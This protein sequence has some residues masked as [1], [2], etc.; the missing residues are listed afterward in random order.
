MNINEWPIAPTFLSL[1]QGCTE[2]TANYNNDGIYYTDYLRGFLADLSHDKNIQNALALFQFVPKDFLPH[3]P[4]AENPNEITK[5]PTK[6]TVVLNMPLDPKIAEILNR[7][8]L[9]IIRIDSGTYVN[10]G[11]LCN[12][13]RRCASEHTSF[14]FMQDSIVGIFADEKLNKLQPNTNEYIQRLEELVEEFNQGRVEIS[15]IKCD[16]FLEDGKIKRLYIHYTCPYSLFEEHIF[17]IYVQERIIACLMFGQVGRTSFDKLKAFNEYMDKMRKFDSVDPY[18]ILSGIM[19]VDENQWEKKARTIV[20]RIEIFEKRLENKI[21]HRNTRYINDRFSDIEQIFRFRIKKIKIKDYKAISEFTEALN[22]AF[23]RIRYN[24]DSSDDGFFRMFALPLTT[25]QKEL[26]LVGW[27]GDISLEEKMEYNFSLKRLR[28]LYYI[29]DIDK[30]KKGEIILNAASQKIRETYN[31]KDVFW[32]GTLADNEV[33]YIVWKR[34]NQQLHGDAFRIYREALKNF[35]SVALECY[36]YIRGAKMELL[37]ETTIQQSAHESAHFIEPARDLVENNLHFPSKKEYLDHCSTNK[38]YFEIEKQ[39]VLALLNQ[40]AEINNG[41]S[42]IF[43]EKITIN[44]QPQNVHDLLMNL[45]R[46]FSKKSADYYKD[47]HY[48]EEKRFVIADIDVAYFNHALYNLVDNAVKYAFDGS[49]IYINMDVDRTEGKLKIQFKSFGIQIKEED[50]EKIYHLFER[51]EDAALSTK[52]TGIGMYIVKKVCE[53]HGGNVWHSSELLSEY[54]LPVLFNLKYNSNLRNRINLGKMVE[55]DKM[56]GKEIN[57][58]SG[59]IENEVVH[60][61]NFIKNL[62]TFNSR[63]N[64]PTYRNIFFVEIPLK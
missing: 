38:K 16:A 2:D 60:D 6:A 21:D 18:I 43:S 25:I 28:G 42:L 12:V 47:I 49:Y 64:T 46:M 24:F 62:I 20:E 58:L 3:D 27:S 13:F 23:N 57:R 61:H 15:K 30:K 4:N 40:L 5:D 41:S 10:N 31:D 22:T 34:H 39:S 52:G 53:A 59:L 44:K 48:V 9:K 55:F 50:R 36:S 35:Y 8:G 33:A 11:R 26:V 1:R 19:Y 29:K 37:L 17:P 51:G 56:Y 32:Y 54:N 63:I 45:K 7:Q 14:C